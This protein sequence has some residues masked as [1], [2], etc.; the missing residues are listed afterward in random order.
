MW[1][2]L[3]KTEEVAR[4]V[5]A[6]RADLGEAPVLRWEPEPRAL[7][8][9]VNGREADV[10]DAEAFAAREGWRVFTYPLAEGDPLG[11]A[12]RDVLAA[13]TSAS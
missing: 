6:R 2:V 11:R 13:M 8:W 7:V 12:K 4:V 10:A 3:A 1:I 5:R 9:L